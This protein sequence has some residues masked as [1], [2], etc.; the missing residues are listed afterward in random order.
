MLSHFRDSRTQG[1]ARQMSEGQP[2]RWI[3]GFAAKG[4]P[5]WLTPA[6]VKLLAQLA[7]LRWITQAP[8]GTPIWQCGWRYYHVGGAEFDE[9]TK[10][11][12]VANT[13][14]QLSN[15]P[16]PFQRATLPK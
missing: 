10:G 11:R 1:G 8:P 4:N 7:E 3:A 14:H 13:S 16:P 15:S 2:H 5:D 6:T 9:G 12:P